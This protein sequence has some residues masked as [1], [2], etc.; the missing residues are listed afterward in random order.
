MRSKVRASIIG[1]FFTLMC[2]F[3]GGIG[4]AT[5]VILPF[6]FFMSMIVGFTFFCSALVCWMWACFVRELYK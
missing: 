1:I 3:G 4:I 2:A 5:I 6:D